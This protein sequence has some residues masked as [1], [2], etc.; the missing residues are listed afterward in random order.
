VA[1]DV[2][3]QT[4][5]EVAG[6]QNDIV[7]GPELALD[8]DNCTPNPEIEKP[9]TSFAL[10]C[11]EGVCLL[12][13]IVL[14]L[15]NVDP[16]PNGS[17]LYTCEF[18]IPES[19]PDGT[20]TLECT[21]PGASD[22]DGN[23]IASACVSGSITVGEVSPTPTDTPAEPTATA[24]PEGTAVPTPTTT[25]GITATA[26]HTP[27]AIPTATFRRIFIDDDD[28]CQIVSPAEAGIAWLL[29]VPPLLLARR[30][31]R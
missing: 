7:F 23:A 10:S 28:T 6:T 25:G 22:P 11:E 18:S 1:I 31:R 30:R 17:T 20:Y 14:A 29:L 24:T 9:A 13:A 2:I 5:A 21:N 12:R 16:I 8:T 4:A 19:T 15:D 26:T 27:P 3:L